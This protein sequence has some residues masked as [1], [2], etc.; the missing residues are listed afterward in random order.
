MF[1]SIF[2]DFLNWL[3]DNIGSEYISDRLRALAGGRTGLENS[4]DNRLALY[5]VSF[6]TFLLNPIIGTCF[7]GG[8][9]GGGHSAI[10]DFMAQYGC[11]GLIVLIWMYV[12]IYKTFYL[13]YKNCKGYGFAVWVFIQSILL[14]IINTGFWFIVLAVFAPL[15]FRYVF[16]EKK[17]ENIV[18]S[19]LSIK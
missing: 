8:Y 4:D 2:S 18:G 19:K 1:S 10:L 14:S 17:N 5:E 12:T 6:K 11:V 7:E 9:V 16:R 15:A 13:P 3:A